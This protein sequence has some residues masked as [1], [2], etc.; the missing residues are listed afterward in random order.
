M[1]NTELN[2]GAAIACFLAQEG[3]DISY[4][5]H[6]GKSPLDLVTDSTVQTLIRS[7]AEKH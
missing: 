4:A 2:V 1:G 6:K 7:F 3:A 5:N